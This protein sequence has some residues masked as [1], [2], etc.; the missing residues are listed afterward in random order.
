M[1]VEL[2]PNHKNFKRFTVGEVPHKNCKIE[3]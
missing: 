3:Q 1:K 2:T